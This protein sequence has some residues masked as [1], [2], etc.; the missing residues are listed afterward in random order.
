MQRP[1]GVRQESI[2]NVRQ[3]STVQLSLGQL[4]GAADAVLRLEEV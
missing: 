3:N 2:P 1:R 4:R